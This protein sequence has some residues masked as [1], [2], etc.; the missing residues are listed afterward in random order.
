MTYVRGE[1][2][3]A[4]A[5]ALASCWTLCEAACT[6][7]TPDE[8]LPVPASGGAVAEAGAGS[9]GG[10]VAS[11]GAGNGV[12]GESNLGGSPPGSAGAM[13]AGGALAT[14]GDA[15]AGAGA[16]GAAGGSGTAG[17][18]ATASGCNWL[19]AADN[20]WSMNAPAADKVVLFDGT[21]LS[22]WHRLNQPTTPAQWKVLPG[23]MMEV[24]PQ[25]TP[26]NIQSN[27]KFED[28]C[29]HVEYWTPAYT[30]GVGVQM[31][32]NSGVYLKSAYEM[33]VLDTSMLGKLI[34]GCG[35]VYKVSPPLVVACTQHE[36]WNTY[37]IEFKG[38]VWDTSSPP[39]K[40]KNAIFVQVALNGQ[41]VQQNVTLNPPGGFTEAGIPDV[42][43]PQ[44]I[45]LQ[46]HRDYVR[47]RN[48]WATV[49]H[50]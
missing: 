29:L 44:P 38:S 1:N 45:A 46:D 36:T 41:L 34:D 15:P 8:P 12:G 32:G 49:P 3:R 42:A 40:T 6:P 2:L 18:A 4:L 10:P 9:S 27:A 17:A 19:K 11:A 30:S 7:A 47:Y 20:T 23:G 24:V 16:P 14:G 28:V 35:A 37:E 21:D 39:S 31:Q 43:G 33:Q 5:V 26:T 50:Y 22:K 13:E 48:I 25:P